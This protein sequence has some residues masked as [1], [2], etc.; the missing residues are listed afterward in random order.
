MRENA[1]VAAGRPAAPGT[2]AAAGLLELLLL[3]L[4]CGYLLLAAAADRP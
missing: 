1:A 3:G 2:G 4:D